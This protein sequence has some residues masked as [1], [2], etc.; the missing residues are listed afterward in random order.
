MNDDKKPLFDVNKAKGE[1]LEHLEELIQRDDAVVTGLPSD[2]KD[3]E[4]IVGIPSNP[5]EVIKNKVEALHPSVA[6][7][8]NPPPVDVGVPLS[9]EHDKTDALI[10]DDEREAIKKGH[11]P[12]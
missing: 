4:G 1:T 3:A 6:D 2:P 5:D 8:H 10:H 12:M 9:I 11:N 7:S